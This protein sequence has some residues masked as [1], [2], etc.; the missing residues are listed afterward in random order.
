[1]LFRLEAL[2][3]MRIGVALIAQLLVLQGRMIV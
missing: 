2:D 1:M 3:Q